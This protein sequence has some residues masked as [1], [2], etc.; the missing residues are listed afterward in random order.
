[1]ARDCVRPPRYIPTPKLIGQ[2]PDLFGGP[3]VTHEAERRPLPKT[4]GRQL[5]AYHLADH[6]ADMEDGQ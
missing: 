4:W 5:L 1:M 3:T 2:Q 6:F